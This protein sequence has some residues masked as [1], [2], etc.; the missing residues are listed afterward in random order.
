MVVNLFLWEKKKRLWW[1]TK[2][3]FVFFFFT[4]LNLILANVELGVF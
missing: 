2:E 1:K 3:N 4:V